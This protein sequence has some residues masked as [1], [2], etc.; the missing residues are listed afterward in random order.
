[1][2]MYT[3]DQYLILGSNVMRFLGQEYP[4]VLMSER[5]ETFHKFVLLVSLISSKLW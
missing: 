1:M 2:K 4:H 3:Q 5:I